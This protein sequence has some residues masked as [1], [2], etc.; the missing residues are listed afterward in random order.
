ME[1]PD[2]DEEELQRIYNWVD[3]IPLSRPKRN[4]SRDFADGVLL[5]EII[6]HFIP[7]LIEIH[8][9]SSA[10]SMQKKMY[11]WSTLNSKVFRK[12]GF[13]LAKKDIDSVVNAEPEAIE[14]ILSAVNVKIFDFLENSQQAANRSIDRSS[15][16]S[17]KAPVSIGQ[18]QRQ[19][20]NA[21]ME[22][23]LIERE[24]TIQ[25]L[26]ETIEIME[27]KIQKLEQLVKIKDS[28]IITLTNKL[29]GAGID[30]P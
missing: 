2:I 6:K 23:A 26:K 28:K 9:Y 12:M 29:A 27:V 22:E 19:K 11:N 1:A 5:A 30:I 25:E 21:A 16:T 14:R 8:N 18:P 20:P 17:I 4:I 15:P 10:S 24:T 7:R 3:E 13:Q